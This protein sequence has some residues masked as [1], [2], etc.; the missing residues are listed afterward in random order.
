[1]N[2]YYLLVWWIVRYLIMFNLITENSM[3]SSSLRKLQLIELMTLLEFKRICDKYNLKYFL[4]GG[5]LLGAVRH[6]GFIPWDDDVDVGMFRSDF[7]K[8]IS[9]CSNELD[10]RWFLQ[11]NDTDNGY[12]NVFAKI[13]LNGTVFKETTDEHALTHTGIYIDIF[14]FDNISSSK[15]SQKMVTLVLNPVERICH[16]KL[17]HKYPSTNNLFVLSYRFFCKFISFVVPKNYVF[18]LRNY[19]LSMWDSKSTGFMHNWPFK[20][21]PTAYFDELVDVEF[22]TVQFPAPKH[23]DEYLTL[24]YGDYMKIPPEN[25]RPK[26]S[27]YEPDF[28]KYAYIKTLDD[29]LPKKG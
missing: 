27:P 29:V 25:E 17:G 22:E 6:K 18:H 26:H 2:E 12:A 8:F 10:S 19:L 23:Y 1:M 4:I 3:D 20:I 21:T 9:I 7:Q 28:G 15:I 5:T 13:R 24:F 11:S 16:Y 14:P